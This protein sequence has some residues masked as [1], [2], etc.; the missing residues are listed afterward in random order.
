MEYSWFTVLVSKWTA[1][2]FSYT[3][4]YTHSLSDSFLIQVITECWVELLCCTCSRSCLVSDLG[5]LSSFLTR[6]PGSWVCSEVGI[7]A[8]VLH[9]VVP[10]TFLLFQLHTP[11]VDLT[12][13]QGRQQSRKPPRRRALNYL[14]L[15]LLRGNG[16]WSKCRHSWENAHT[17]ILTEKA[18]WKSDLKSFTYARTFIHRCRRVE[19]THMFSVFYLQGLQQSWYFPSYNTL[20]VLKIS[21]NML[22]LCIYIIC[23]YYNYSRNQAI[24]ILKT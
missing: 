6:S 7:W 24:L 13:V 1:K 16:V 10:L 22:I 12:L 15:S 19:H 8:S 17:N 2:W 4:T 3:Y 5:H 21:Y 18:G 20:K 23:L 9:S 11:W 14:E